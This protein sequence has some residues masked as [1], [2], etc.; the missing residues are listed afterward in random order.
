MSVKLMQI[1]VLLMNPCCIID[2]RVLSFYKLPICSTTNKFVQLKTVAGRQT[3]KVCLPAS[4]AVMPQ[5]FSLRRV[6]ILAI[7]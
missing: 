4:D 3:L 6:F 1:F 2:T 7:N 5:G